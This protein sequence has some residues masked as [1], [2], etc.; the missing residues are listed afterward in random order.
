MRHR[1]EFLTTLAARY[2]TP[3]FVYFMDDVKQ[4]I[5]QLRQAFHGIFQISYAMKCNPHP[6][7]LARM[8]DQVNTLDVSSRGELERGLCAGFDP[9]RISFTGPAK[10]DA[11]LTLAVKNRIGE[12]V[13]ESVAEARRLSRIAQARGLVQ[14][15]LVRIAPKQVP[16]GFG[17]NMAGRPCQFGIDEED[18]DAALREIR[19]LPGLALRGFHIYSGTQC[20]KADAIAENYAIFMDI[21]RRI[22]KAYGIR[23]RKLIFGSGLGIPYHDDDAPLD[24]DRLSAL[25]LPS[26]RQFKAE[27]LFADSALLLET[28]RYLVGEAG[29]YLTRVVSRKRSRGVEIAICDGGMHHHLG[30]CGHLGMVIHRPYRMSNVSAAQGRERPEGSFDLYGPLCTSIDMLGRGVK[31]PELL[32]DDVIAVGTSGAYG[33]SASPGGFISHPPPHE[34]FIESDACGIPN[35]VPTDTARQEEL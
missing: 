17:V 30:A 21:F 31:L 32:V 15:V 19:D 11:C 23:P 33:V 10:Q 28:G 1:D 2:G 27:P 5:E 25:S 12:V 26:L 4:R 9:S 35:V 13:L 34:L 29:V 3:S 8:R 14:D 22:S 6:A 16:K 18:L 20:L 7:L 24:L